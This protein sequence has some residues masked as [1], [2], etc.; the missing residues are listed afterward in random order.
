MT[1]LTADSC[2][3]KNLFEM[4]PFLDALKFI[5]THIILAIIFVFLSLE[6]IDWAI[7][8][9]RKNLNDQIIDNTSWNVNDFYSGFL[10]VYTKLV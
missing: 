7:Y 6:E 4:D 3:Y 1:S 10:K 5:F 2:R 8:S 9:S